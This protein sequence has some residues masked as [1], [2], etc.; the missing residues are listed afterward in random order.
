M[1]QEPPTTPPEGSAANQSPSAP[2]PTPRATQSNLKK[3]W[4]LG[5]QGRLV[6][7]FMLLL[8]LGLESDG[9]LYASQT[10]QRLVELLGEQARQLAWGLSLS[11][12]QSITAHQT[13]ALRQVGQ[14]LLR[15]RNVLFV[16]FYDAD[17]RP[18]AFSHRD[19]DYRATQLNFKGARP[20]ALMQVHLDSSP[21]LGDYVEVLA[22]ILTRP[23]AGDASMSTLKSGQR[24]LGY[25]A[26][27]VSQTPEQAQLSRINILA[28]VI[29]AL[30]VLGSLPLVFLLVHRIFLP[31]RELVEATNKIA[32]GS[33]DTQVAV[34]RSDVIG[35]LARSFNE[36]VKTVKRQQDDLAA[37]NKQLDHDLERAL[38]DLKIKNAR[39]EELAATDPL[40]GLYNRR[41]FGRV[42]EQ[43][44]S[45]A[46]RYSDDLAC[47]MIDLDGYKPI[48][49]KFGHAVGD[50]LL[51]VA[52]KVISA[53]MRRMDV[54]ARYGGDEFV[55]LLP[56]ANGDDA[57]T[58]A[59]RIREE[60]Q[61]ASAAVLQREQGVTMSVGIVALRTG[62]PSRPDQL[63]TQADA[64]LYQAKAA[65]RNRSIVLPDLATAMQ[66]AAKT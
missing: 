61:V 47:V 66:A 29:A 33:Y 65:G 32:S 57:A 50:Q 23:T 30:V 51:V 1:V 41:H 52:A 14:D 10:S 49:D 5:L 34:D 38:A 27:G 22:P 42:L 43:L 37:A 63:V 15:T 6:A 21:V 39:L 60:Y 31:I 17:F 40:T 54:A 48:N 19:P 28:G 13:S 7:A 46:S 26:V 8:M 58:V 12:Q 11:S 55:L 64:A 20:A 36:M 16:V 3:A 53:N 59:E 35:G 2:G 18:V 56:R 45:E 4:P 9:L 44:F 24:L 25:V 62:R